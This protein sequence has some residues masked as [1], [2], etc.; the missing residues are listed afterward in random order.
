MSTVT[1]PPIPQSTGSALSP[2]QRLDLYETR[3]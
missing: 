2:E 3:S 1:S